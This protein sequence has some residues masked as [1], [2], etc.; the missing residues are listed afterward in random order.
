MP[1]GECPDSLLVRGRVADN[2]WDPGERLFLRVPPGPDV[3]FGYRSDTGTLRE[4]LELAKQVIR[5]ETSNGFRPSVNR[6]KYSIAEDARWRAV[7]RCHGVWSFVAG[8]AA[9]FNSG[10]GTERHRARMEHRPLAA[11][12]CEEGEN[13]AH[14]EVVLLDRGSPI[15]SKPGKAIR[16]ALRSALADSMRRELRARN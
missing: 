16:L 5:F 2:A 3:A 14:A 11:A 15:A 4:R 6:G 10:S 13:Y 8:G 7:W 9:A 1:E 12:D